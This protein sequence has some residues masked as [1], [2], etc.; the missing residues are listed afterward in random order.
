MTDTTKVIVAKYTGESR[1]RIP[2]GL[3]VE[4]LQKDGDL[5]VRWDKLYIKIDDEWKMIKPHVDADDCINW[6]RATDV[7]V[8]TFSDIDEGEVELKQSDS[9]CRANNKKLIK[10]AGN[11]GEE[12]CK[13]INYYLH[14]PDGTEE[15]YC[16]DCQSS[17][18]DNYIK[19]ADYRGYSADEIFKGNAHP[20]YESDQDESDDDELICPDCEKVLN[21]DVPTVTLENQIKFDEKTVCQDCWESFQKQYEAEGFTKTVQQ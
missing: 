5:Y 18:N 8:D 4:K 11:C 3:D 7:T 6:E 19:R 21:P 10:C 20:E 2:M 17:L 16:E 14:F 12:L 15:W 1:F 13:D 9:D